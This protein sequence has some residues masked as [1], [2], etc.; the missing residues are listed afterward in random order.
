M[1]ALPR[2]DTDPSFCTVCC[3]PGTRALL[4]KFGPAILDHLTRDLRYS[5]TQEA[6][7]S[8][9]VA[10]SPPEDGAEGLILRR[11]RNRYTL[12]WGVIHQS[13]PTGWFATTPATVAPD[14]R[15]AHTVHVNLVSQPKPLPA[16]QPVEPAKLP[17]RVAAD[18]IDTRYIVQTLDRIKL[19]QANTPYRLHWDDKSG[20]WIFIDIIEGTLP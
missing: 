13:E 17:A 2:Y 8:F 11:Q 1:T 10:P 5:L 9:L 6:K 18:P 12:S 19:I 16:P 4:I 3:Y 14:P 15:R 20:R 7:Y